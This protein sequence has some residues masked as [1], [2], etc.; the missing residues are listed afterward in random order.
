MITRRIV[1]NFNHIF[2]AKVFFF[3][4]KSIWKYLLCSIVLGMLVPILSWSPVVS[5]F[6]YFFGIMLLLWPLLYL[7]SKGLAS[8]IDFDANIE[9]A[10]DQITIRHINKELEEI[11]S[12]TWIKKIVDHED[13]F[14]L[15]VD[16]T[17]P[18]GIT[19]PKSNLSQA[20]IDFLKKMKNTI[21]PKTK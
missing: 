1:S 16:K 2:R 11:K 21:H 6:I 12:W 19:I 17:I 3:F 8:K 15:I 7:S 18:N 13:R 4:R 20:E 5:I 10:E 14:W 9:F